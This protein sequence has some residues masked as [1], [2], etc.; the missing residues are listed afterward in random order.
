MADR[1]C[2]GNTGLTLLAHVVTIAEMLFVLI[3]MLTPISGAHFNPVVTLAFRFRDEL[4]GI[5]AFAYIL[6]QIAGAIVGVLVVHM[7]FAEQIF[8]IGITPRTGAGQWLGEV[9]A[10]FG[11][12]LTIFAVRQRGT[13]LTAASVALYIASAVWFTAST[14]FANP[15]VTL[16]RAL[17]ATFTSIRPDDTIGFIVAQFV[18]MVLALVVERWLF[19]DK[20]AGQGLKE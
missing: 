11:L 8:Q 12:M 5:D 14:S 19:V 7:M 15:A 16:A 9:V 6:A 2:Q 17:T 18:G 3:V 1:L 10:T 4:S 13:V 20:V